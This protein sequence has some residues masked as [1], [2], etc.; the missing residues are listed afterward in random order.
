VKHVWN[1]RL[2]NYL[3]G[4]F[5]LDLAAKDSCHATTAHPEVTI[6]VSFHEVPFFTQRPLGSMYVS[7]G[8]LTGM[9]INFDMF[10]VKQLNSPR[11]TI[12][13]GIPDWQV[14]STTPIHCDQR[15]PCAPPAQT[16][17]SIS[18]IRIL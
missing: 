15:T 9:S 12:R 18:A 2:L 10:H 16:K 8:T 14:R 6:I 7:R 4:G 5:S 11:L 3:D 17:L 1:D 13:A